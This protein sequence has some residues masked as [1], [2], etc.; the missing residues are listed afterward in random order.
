MSTQVEKDIIRLYEHITRLSEG[1]GDVIAQLER[2]FGIY[3]KNFEA[4]AEQA[5]TWDNRT[6]ELNMRLEKA[7]ATINALVAAQQTQSDAQRPPDQD[8][9][10]YMEL[11]GVPWDDA[12]RKIMEEKE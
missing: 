2:S 1:M 11:H 5:K 4:A 10:A 7:E 3:N 12:I 8:I 6:K 9:I